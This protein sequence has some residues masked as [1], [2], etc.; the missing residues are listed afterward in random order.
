MERSAQ[1]RCSGAMNEKGGR[2]GPPVGSAIGRGPW[3]FAKRKSGSRPAGPDARFRSAFP[4]F[5]GRAP[6]WRAAGARVY[7]GRCACA[8]VP[9]SDGLCD[10]PRPS[11]EAARRDI[12]MDDLQHAEIREAVRKLCEDFPGP[13][14]RRLDRAMAYPTEFVAALTRAGFLNALIPEEYGGAGLPLSAAA[15]IL[16]EI[17]HAGCSGSACHAQMYILNTLL[18]HGSDEQKRRYLPAIASGELSLQA[19]GVTEPSSGTDTLSL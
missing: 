7:G 5:R 2:P 13:Y 12:T 9:G 6:S 14:W 4:V 19:F 10:L 17:Q 8:I 1:L 3:G 11:R 16:E 15:A 18:R